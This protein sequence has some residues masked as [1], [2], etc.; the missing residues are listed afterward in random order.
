MGRAATVAVSHARDQ[1]TQRLT[2]HELHHQR[3]LSVEI[4]QT[5][6][7]HDVRMGQARERGGLAHEQ[8][9][10]A[11][12]AL[13][14]RM[15]QL[16]RDRVWRRVREPA[17]GIVVQPTAVDDAH[18]AFTDGVTEHRAT[19][20]FEIELRTWA[21]TELRWFDDQYPALRAEARLVDN[22]ALACRTD[23]HGSEAYR[24]S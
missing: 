23:R 7:V 15:Q 9:A 8:L 24:K 10:R 19:P 21:D 16:H 11:R 14:Q 20:V 6:E 1:L 4:R 13:Q 5:E 3:E 18:A 17:G 12:F 22:L 2:V